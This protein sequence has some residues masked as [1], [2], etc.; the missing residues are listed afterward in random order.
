MRQ[1]RVLLWAFSDLPA[2]KNIADDAAAL[3]KRLNVQ[4]PGLT[5]PYRQA[6]DESKFKQQV[7]DDER[8]VASLEA[9]VS[10]NLDGLR[11]AGQKRGQETKRWQA[12]YDVTLARLEVEYVFLL[13]YESML[14]QMRKELPPLAAGQSGWKLVSQPALHGDPEGKKLAREA[15]K[16]LDTVVQNHPGTPWEVLA[17]QLKAAPLGLEWKGVTIP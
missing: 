6:A 14:G 13:E 3:R 10:D 1:A 5:D 8:A 11:A 12:N 2:P 16:L 15:W 17:E 7:Y 9:E 4:L